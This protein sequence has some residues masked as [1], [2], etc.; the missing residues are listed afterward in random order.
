MSTQRKP[1]NPLDEFS[2]YSV[3]YIMVAAR[4]TVAAQAFGTNDENSQSTAIQAINN[5]Q[6]LGDPVIINGNDTDVFLILDT[7]RF[8]Q[9][10]VESL[11]YDVFV[12]GIEKGGS[13]A[14]LATDLSMT[15]TD[16]VGISFANFLQYV[17]DE[18][19]KTNYDGMVF[20]L[21]L[22]FVGHLDNGKS[23]LVQS[24]TIPMHLMKMDINL[25]YA[26][27]LYTLEFMPNMNF[28]PVK[29][30]RFLTV[31]TATTYHS[32]DNTVGGMIASFEEQLN[33][34]SDAYYKQVQ[35]I[36]AQARQN[37]STA[38][39]VGNQTFGRKVNYM[40]T[41]PNRWKS[42]KLSGPSLGSVVEQS[43]KARRDEARREATEKITK[44]S[45]GQTVD[46]IRDSYVATRSGATITEVLDAVFKQVPE[47]AE[48]GNFKSQAAVEGGSVT[49]FKYILGMTSDNST[50]MIH[51]DVIEFVIPNVFGSQLQTTNVSNLD[52]EFYE[53]RIDPVTK[54][55][56]RIPKDFLEWD[57][58]FSGRNDSILNF[59]MKIEDFQ[60]LLAS[61]MRIGDGAMKGVEETGQTPDAA[62]ASN[63][64]LLYARQFDPLVLPLDSD[65]A[66]RNFSRYSSA[67]VSIEESADR[68]AK[69]Q[70][71]SK[72]L[73]MFYAG[74]PIVAVVTIKGNP[75][76]LT[77]FN[78][79]NLLQ[80]QTGQSNSPSGTAGGG[81]SIQ[82]ETYRKDLE[83]RILGL[84]SDLQQRSDGSIT[85]RPNLSSKSYATSPVFAKINI[86][87]PKVDF[88]TNRPIED[89]KYQESVLSDN[90]YVIFKTSHIIQGNLFTQELELYVHNIFGR[91]KI[92]KQ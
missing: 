86:F 11:K 66:I 19:L 43:F 31:S 81:G 21:R 3:Q 20:M 39:S 26:K 35:D 53:V 90:Y 6:N 30:A 89:G 37:R 2:S 76:I 91:S 49:F 64:E 44:G 78:M 54:R 48:M 27:G 28:D 88:A 67:A 40:I 80:H 13:P 14:N 68:N 45:N 29:N 32:K 46:Q 72:N 10:T 4:T 83:R 1:F 58:I 36:L 79:G 52:N 41:V 16:S 51:V 71:Y 73:S 65:S 61:N 55:E 33:K 85:T 47:I 57:Y 42:W 7:R 82:R 9:F 77:K 50:V 5:A 24:E 70:Q 34:K 8:S 87:G 60:F 23:K 74:S 69:A 63:D 56:K 12:N 22:L 18:K 15:I 17:M 75:F 38:A 84:N 59:D 92:T 25:D 62:S